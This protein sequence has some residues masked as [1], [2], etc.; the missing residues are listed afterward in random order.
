VGSPT[1]ARS[2]PTQPHK[3]DGRLR[4]YVGIGCRINFDVC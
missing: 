2:R 4:R 1:A 3:R